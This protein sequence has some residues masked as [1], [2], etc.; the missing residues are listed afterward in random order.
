MRKILFKP[1]FIGISL[2]VLTL[3]L[4][5]VAIAFAQAPDN[6][7]FSSATMITELPF[8]STINTGEATTAGDDPVGC[9]E[10]NEGA[11]VWYAFTPPE[12]MRI[13]IDVSASDYNATMVVATGSPGS[14]NIITCGSSYSQEGFEAT[15][16]T[17]YY[18]M[19]GTLGGGPGGNLVFSVNGLPPTPPFT[20]QFHLD[21]AGSV[22]T[23]TGA[24]TL[25]GT[26]TCSRSAYANVFGHL[27]QRVGRAL[28][29]SVVTLG[30]G[31]ICDGETPWTT[32]FS[33]TDGNFVAGK[34]KVLITG[35]ASPTD[36]LSPTVD[37][38]IETTVTLKGKK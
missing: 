28:L 37:Q 25:H 5:S 21:S 10:L 14:F 3:M 33:N 27:E 1:R 30:D 24:V 34:A 36:G 12:D 26:I 2:L 29:R 13:V 19:I 16:G 23:K 15:A 4:L 35:Y 9:F 32:T 31:I 18:F 7:N 11:T 38:T 20:M 22:V 8:E 6:D 17:T